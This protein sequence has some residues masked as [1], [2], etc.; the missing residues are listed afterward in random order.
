VNFIT[1]H[2]GFTLSDLV[3]YDEKHN[4]ANGEHNND[5]PD[6][7]YSCNHGHEGPTDDPAIQALRARQQ[8]NL[9]GTLL[10][11][12]GT[13]MLLSGDEFGHT[14]GGNNN[15]YCQDNELAWLDWLAAAQ[16]SEL[17]A[18][19]RHLLKLRQRYPLLRR[20][21]FLTGIPGG[22]G[23]VRDVTWLTPQ[24]E[25][26]EQAGWDD[27]ASCS[28]GMLLDG[29]AAESA[30]RR[31]GGEYSLLLLVHAGAETMTFK[32]PPTPGPGDWQLLVSSGPE[33]A[34]GSRHAGDADLALPPRTLCLLRARV[35]RG[36]R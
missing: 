9:L 20:K 12:Q 32:L 26:M 6:Y 10:L 29:R 31:P 35:G 8:R 33:L 25:A 36:R 14:Q 5:G 19:V 22:H 1:A 16:G 23:D 24:G 11:S 21:H 18:Y 30:N 27:P 3:S 2:D 4:E 7:N 15:A 13:P 28:I 17:A 34:N